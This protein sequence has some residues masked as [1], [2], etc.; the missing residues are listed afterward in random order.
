MDGKN[1]LDMTNNLTV[2]ELAGLDKAKDLQSVLLLSLMYRLM[3]YITNPD[4]RQQRKYLILDEAWALLKQES[5]AAFLEEAARALARFRCCAMFMTQQVSDFDSPAAQAVKN[6]SGN[7]VLLQQNPEQIGIIAELFDLTEQEV[8]LLSKVHVRP[9]WGEAFLWQPDGAG[10]SSAW[11]PIR[12]CA[13]W[14]A[15][16]RTSGAPG[17]S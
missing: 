11:F 17:R 1:Q 9:N 13:G 16:S 4:A 5:A 15:R 2:F 6:N 3:K 12:S 7:Y 10:E 8:R 14:R